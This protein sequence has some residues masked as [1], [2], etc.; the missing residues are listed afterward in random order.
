MGLVYRS[1]AIAISQSRSFSTT[2]SGTENPI[3]EGGA[4]VKSG[5]TDGIDWKAVKTAGGL[6]SGTQVAPFTNY[7][8][9]LALLSG[10]RP[11]HRVSCVLHVANQG[12]RNAGTSSHEVE[13]LLRSDITANSV[14]LYECNIGYS[15]ATGFYSQIIKI[16][17]TFIP[18]GQMDGGNTTP[19]VFDG[20]IFTAEIIGTTT[21]TINSYL[22]GSLIQTA[23]DNGS[24]V[25]AAYTT[26]QPGI[27][28]F[29]RGTENQDDFCFTSATFEDL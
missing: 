22:N 5:L 3:S 17:G 18:A 10:F 4:W 26:G 2:F 1:N 19:D 12:A 24:Y 21:P 20:D 29:W 7:D 14:F 16:D 28:F 23:T 25:G 8:D 27:G 9:S 6:A 13:I 11:I 15:G